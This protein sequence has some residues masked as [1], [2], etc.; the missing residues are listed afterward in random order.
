MWRH[1]TCLLALV[2]LSAPLL[3]EQNVNPG[4]NDH[5]QNPDVSQWR[6]VFERDGREVWDRRDDIIRVLDLQPGMAIAE[7]SSGNTGIGLTFV[8]AHKG[9][10]VVIVMPE[11]MSEE[12]RKIIRA[13][14]GELVYTSAEGSLNEA[15]ALDLIEDGTIEARPQPDDGANVT[16]MLRRNFAKVDWTMPATPGWDNS[17]MCMFTGDFEMMA[18]LKRVHY[19]TA[20]RLKAKRIVMGECGHAFRSIYD[21]GNRAL[22]WKFPPIPV[23]SEAPLPACLSCAHAAGTDPKQTGD[24]TAIET[25]SAALFKQRIAAPPPL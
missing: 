19:E 5:Y 22:G 23:V 21:V 16:P 13:F 20:F 9:Y 25:A 1:L 18:R 15:V 11:D 17:D 24:E 12:R 14:G 7:A 6:G 10:R 4:I 3:A 2:V 8:G